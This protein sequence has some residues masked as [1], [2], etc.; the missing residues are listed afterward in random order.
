VQIRPWG[1]PQQDLGLGQPTPLGQPQ[2]KNKIINLQ[3]KKKILLPISYTY[4]P[5]FFK[6]QYI[7]VLNI[8]GYEFVF[9]CKFLNKQIKLSGKVLMKHNDFF[10]FWLFM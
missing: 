9:F 6:V 3:I 5:F 10:F 1:K 2:R 8:C 4:A 7:K